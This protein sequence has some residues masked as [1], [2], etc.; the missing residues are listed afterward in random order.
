[1]I[2][3]LNFCAIDFE[4]ATYNRM[5]CQV[6]L[7]IVENGEIVDTIVKLIQPPDNYY[8]ENTIRVH[9]ITPDVT[10]NAPTF[11]I[12]W[13]EIS[14]YI[15][16]NTVVAHNAIFDQDVLMRNL[17]YYG[18]MPM[19]IDEFVCTYKIFGHSLEDMC[20]AFSIDCC[21]HHDAG[22]DAEC[23]AIFYINYKSGV[24]PDYTLVKHN[25]HTIKIH[26]GLHGDVL[27][28]DLSGANP[29]NPFYDR[30]IVITGVFMQPRKQLGNI[31]K[32]MGAD[33]DNSITK[34]TN[35]VL[36]GED[37]G[38]SKME[39]L[40]KLIHDGFNIKKIYQDDLNNIL[41][42]EWNGYKAERT[43][44]K[45]LDFTMDHYNKHHVSFVGLQN[46]IATKELYFGKGF[47][48]KA[49]CFFQITGNLGALGNWQLD[50]NVNICVL[51][52]S[53]LE[54]LK[55]GVKDETI[56]YIQDYYNNNK[57]ITFDFEFM[58]EQDILDLCKYRCEI[59]G[60]KVT[61]NLYDI[62]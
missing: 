12:V 38:P 37:P 33:I 55:E 52:N 7:T 40:D 25:P 49:D 56:Q 34:R 59:F 10:A 15:V 35:F 45:D 24:E 39:K 21:E 19:G 23:C 54:K 17:D 2:E 53:T 27:Q 44:T 20:Q 62:Y 48:E 16:G 9:H 43:I 30:K 26:E 11:D 29:D 5:A 3:D 61:M 14:K 22:F 41:N 4:T 6:G 47:R 60:D 8:D 31:L 13:N 42:G 58:S 1:M 28:K 57:A 32:A 36:I 18:I 46:R 50:N 51:S